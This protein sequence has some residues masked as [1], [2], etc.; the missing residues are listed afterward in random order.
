VGKFSAGYLRGFWSS[1]REIAAITLPHGLK[2]NET[3]KGAAIFVCQRPHGT[4]AQMWRW[5]RHYD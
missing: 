1:V 3:A 4:W 5:L 2:D